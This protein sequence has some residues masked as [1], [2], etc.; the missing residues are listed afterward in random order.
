[1]KTYT[2]IMENLYGDT[3]DIVVRPDKSLEY[4]FFV[5]M[6]ICS[7]G[8]IAALGVSYKKETVLVSADDTTVIGSGEI[9][10]K[11]YDKLYFVE[12]P[13]KYC[14]LIGANVKDLI[15][16]DKEFFYEEANRRAR[17]E[18]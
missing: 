10:E 7:N 8:K 18:F 14:R 5:P 17:S 13:D 11:T 6:S 2:E 16:C 3:F 9:D 12:N 4:R 1:M 15:G